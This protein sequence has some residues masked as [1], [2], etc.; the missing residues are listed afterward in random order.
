MADE[1]GQFETLLQ[2]LLSP[3]NTVRSQ[4]EVS[5]LVLDRAAISVAWCVGSSGQP[6]GASEHVAPKRGRRACG[7]GLGAVETSSHVC[8]RCQETCGR[9]G[10]RESGLLAPRARVAVLPAH[11]MSSINDNLGRLVVV[12]SLC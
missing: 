2:N 3:D 5:V 12:P 1:Q 7:A 6:A 4:A 10:T 11:H 9:G 8:I